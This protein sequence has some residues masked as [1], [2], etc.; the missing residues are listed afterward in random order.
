MRRKSLVIWMVILI[1]IDAAGNVMAVDLVFHIP[2]DVLTESAE[3]A[4]P[5]N[6]F[7]CHASPD[8]QSFVAAAILNTFPLVV[9]AE[10]I[11]DGKHIGTLLGTR[12]GSH[13]ARTGGHWRAPI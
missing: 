4:F 2:I 3:V 5:K 10:P 12:L 9:R 13:G 8:I 11:N 7:V 6:V 1:G